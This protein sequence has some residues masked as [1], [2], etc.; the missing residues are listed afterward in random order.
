MGRKNETIYSVIVIHTINYDSF[1]H[2][3]LIMLFD[4][5]MGNLV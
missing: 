4:P 1:Y 5:V 2:N 3:A